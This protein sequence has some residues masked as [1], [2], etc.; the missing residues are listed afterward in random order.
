MT[1]RSTRRPAPAVVLVW[2]LSLLM[3]ACGFGGGSGEGSPPTTIPP[4]YVGEWTAP[5]QSLLLTEHAEIRYSR[6]REGGST[7]SIAG[8]LLSFS[9]KGFSAG[10][11]PLA[12]TFRIDVPPYR[13]GLVWRMTVDDVE[14]VRP[15]EEPP[16]PEV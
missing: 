8:P 7:L 14:L 12:T 15:A 16:P 1:A 4:E 9:P 10:F 11:G 3:S 13:D 5:G 2:L 6:L